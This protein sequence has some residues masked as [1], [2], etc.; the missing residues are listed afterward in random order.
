M[1]GDLV[2]VIN[3]PVRKSTAEMGGG[4]SAGS[5]SAVT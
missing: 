1:L 2:T 5:I 3:L 4:K